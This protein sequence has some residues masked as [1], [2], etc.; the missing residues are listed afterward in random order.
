MELAG[1]KAPETMD[2]RSI[3]P[4]LVRCSESVILLLRLVVD[5]MTSI[6][7]ELRLLLTSVGVTFCTLNYFN[8]FRTLNFSNLLNEYSN[9]NSFPLDVISVD[10]AFDFSN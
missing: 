3:L 6:K 8:Y 7:M 2:G 1:G 9:P 10:V 5:E 4:L